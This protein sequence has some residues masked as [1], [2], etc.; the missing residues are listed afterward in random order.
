MKS[1][2]NNIYDQSLAT[3]VDMQPLKD[4]L[5]LF[6]KAIIE[7]ENARPYHLYRNYTGKKNMILVRPMLYSNLLTA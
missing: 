1:A 7:N 3:L 2:M 5:L 4:S 6:W